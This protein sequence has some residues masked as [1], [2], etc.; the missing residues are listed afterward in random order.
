M[1]VKQ[2]FEQIQLRRPPNRL[3]ASEY[4]AYGLAELSW[5]AKSE[6]LGSRAID[7]MA[8]V[9]DRRSIVLTRDKLVAFTLLRQHGI[10]FPEVKAVVHPTRVFPGA[11]SLT[12][13]E[14]VSR[15]LETEANFPIFMKPNAGNGGFGSIWVD[16]YADGSL[17]LRDGTSLPLGPY[18]DKWLV[19]DGLVLQAVA[20]PHP[21]IADVFGPRLSTAR[22]VVLVLDGGPVVH[23]ATLRI[24]AGANMV[25][26][27]RHGA[28]GNLLGA[29]DVDSGELYN[30]VGKKGVDLASVRT[31]PDTGRE[32]VG[33]RVPDW[34]AAKALCIGAAPLFTG[35]RF[36]SWD[37]AFTDQGPQV[38]EVNAEGDFDVLQLAAGRGIADETWW[39]L[40]R[41]PKAPAWRRWFVRNGP[42]K[43]GG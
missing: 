7:A 39:Q 10:P 14:A 25:D 33:L 22:I 36:Q 42:W 6:F 40:C 26:N 17:Q 16:G 12:G 4:A 21:V 9:N 29:V 23:R 2:I 34:E 41:E 15:Y 24:P 19:L 8:V 37:I 5:E 1:P 20:R 30:V 3:T 43:R 31:H 38:M 28:S 11:R 27:F 32:I 18:I 35:I 13:K